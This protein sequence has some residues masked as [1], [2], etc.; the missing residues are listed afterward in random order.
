MRNTLKNVHP[1]HD[2]KAHSNMLQKV[3]FLAWLLAK[4]ALDFIVPHAHIK[5]QITCSIKRRK[6][7]LV[8]DVL[9]VVLVGISFLQP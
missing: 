9:Y 3:T 1:V 7:E 4:K 6:W 8:M 5:L 2:P